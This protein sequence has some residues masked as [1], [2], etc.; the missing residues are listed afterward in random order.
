MLWYVAEAIQAATE[1]PIV[2]H[3]HSVDR[4]EYE[5]GHEPNPWLAHSQAQDQA[6]AASDR[7]IALTRS[8]SEL[9]IRY[10]PAMRAKIRIVGNGIEDSDAARAA[11]SRT[12]PPGPPL[13]LY[14]GR[15]VERKGIRELLDA[16]PQVLDAVPDVQFVLAGGPPPL[17]GDEVAAQWLTPQHA[18]YRDRIHF[19]GWL[20]PDYVYR[21]YAAADI[22]VV[23]SRYEPFGMVVL[24]GMLH[25]L[26]IIAA[27][28]GGPAD[29]LQHGT[30]GLLFPPRNV[31]VLA[32]TLRHLI[33]NGD[34]RRRMGIGAAQEVRRRWLWERLVP[35]ML[36]VYQEFLPKTLK[37]GRGA[38]LECFAARTG[39]SSGP[40]LLAAVS[41]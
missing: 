3:V 20:S 36:E 39:L 9:L 28:I 25:G 12:R 15:L 40:T 14:S 2:Y 1:T 27:D 35:E 34:D 18:R 5:I 21:W 38:A 31:D 30:T 4:A 22:L 10:Y 7:L 16:V 11:A 24:E 41:G 23:P 37:P 19:T 26:P 29:I 33:E 8:E 17:T 13:V 32:A 6:I